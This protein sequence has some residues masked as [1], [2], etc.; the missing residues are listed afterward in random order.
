M[1]SN[2]TLV[3][4]IDFGTTRSGYYFAFT[5]E[6]PQIVY[7][8]SKWRGAPEGEKTLTELLLK[9]DREFVAFGYE[10]RNKYASISDK[11]NYLYFSNFKMVLH[12]KEGIKRS[13]V[14]A[15]NCK[16]T[17][18]TVDLV[19]ICLRVIKER[20]EEQ[21]NTTKKVPIAPNEILWVVTVPAIWDVTARQAMTTAAQKAG[22]PE[23]NILIA[24]E[25]EAAVMACLNNPASKEGK[26]PEIDHDFMVVDAGGGTVDITVHRQAESGLVELRSPSGGAWGS[27]HINKKFQKLLVKLFGSKQKGNRL[28]MIMDTFE[29]AKVSFTPEDPCGLVCVAPINSANVV[30]AN[31]RTAIAAYNSHGV[32]LEI[33]EQG[34]MLDFTS[35][36]EKHLNH[37]ATKI[38]SHIALLLMQPELKQVKCLYLV[39]GFAECPVLKSSI[40]GKFGHILKVIIPPAPGITVPKGAVLY[41][42]NPNFIKERVMPLTIGVAI[43]IPWSDEDHSGRSQMLNGDGIRFCNETVKQCV[44][45]G[46]RISIGHEVTIPVSPLTTTQEAIA[47][48]VYASKKQTIKFINDE[49]AWR[50]GYLIIDIPAVGKGSRSADC[51]LQ[52]GGTTLV[53]K[54]I[55][56]ATG[57]SKKGKFA[58]DLDC[59][60]AVDI[61]NL[62][63]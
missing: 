19:S 18:P 50:I 59:N 25:P 38:V 16:A 45:A 5:A 11:E 4:A 23:D 52:F 13:S 15:S 30:N 61:R 29:N 33:D 26:T 46:Q 56:K 12:D 7:A 49:G 42:L 57:E 10:A 54:I 53:Y 34:Q 60:V 24:L 20:A 27:F 35:F 36:L 51:V 43:T 55:S 2:Y 31:L 44:S 63:I 6:S 48:C 3:I 37:L 41:G 8:N 1:T 58:F 9:K 62:T 22:M 32:K 14:E 28:N 17:M 40:E 47:L 21:V 39:G